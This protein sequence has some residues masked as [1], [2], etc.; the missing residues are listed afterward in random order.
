[1]LKPGGFIP[2][3]DEIMVVPE[4]TTVTLEVTRCTVEASFAWLRKL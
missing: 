4:T 1:M 2:L 3:L